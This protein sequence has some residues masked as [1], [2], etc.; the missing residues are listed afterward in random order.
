MAC[1]QCRLPYPG[2]LLVPM[3]VQG[4]YTP[5]ICGICALDVTNAHHGSQLTRFQGEAAEDMRQRALRWRKK[6]P[7]AQPVGVRG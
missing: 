6:H 4:E 3:M 7:N 2:H 1:G 5:P